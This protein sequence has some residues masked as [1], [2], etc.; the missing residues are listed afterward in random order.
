[1]NIIFDYKYWGFN[2]LSRKRYKDM[3]GSK[4]GACSKCGKCE[5]ACTQKLS[6]MSEMKFAAKNFGE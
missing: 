3:K 4:A 5:K 2:K 1:M 6:I